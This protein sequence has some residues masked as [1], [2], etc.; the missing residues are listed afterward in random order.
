M[1]RQFK[2]FAIWFVNEYGMTQEERYQRTLDEIHAAAK[3]DYNISV[4]HPERNTTGET[5]IDEIHAAAKKDY[6]ADIRNFMRRHPANAAI[7]GLDCK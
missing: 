2:N 1:L 5:V 4:G 6:N 3:R 7:S